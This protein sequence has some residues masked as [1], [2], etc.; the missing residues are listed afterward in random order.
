MKKII[1]NISLLFMF[2]IPFINLNAVSKDKVNYDVDAIYINSEIEIGGAVKF[3]EIIKVSG[4][5]NGYIRDIVYKNEKLNKFKGKKEDFYG[6]DIYNGSEIVVGRVGILNTDKLT[7]ENFENEFIEENVDFFEK[8]SDSTYEISDINNGTSIKMYKET[9]N[10]ET[11]FYLEYTILDLAVLHNDTAELYYNFIGDDFADDIGEVFAVVYLP[12]QDEEIKVWAHGPLNGEAFILEG[13]YGAALKINNLSKYTPIDLRILYNKEQYSILLNENKKS[14]MDAISLIKDVEEERAKTAN[15][16]RKRS[17]IIYYSL[18]SSDILYIIGILGLI[19][20]TYLKYDKEYKSSFFNKYNREFIEDYDVEIISYLMNKNINS[21]AF[22]SSILNLI[23]KKN[24]KVEKIN[25]KKEDYKFILLNKDNL[26]N[27]ENKIINLLF[28]EIGSNNE[29]LMSEIKKSSKNVYDSNKNKIYDTFIDWK[30]SVYNESLKQEFFEKNI[31]VKLLLSLYT[32]L[33]IFLG[34]LSINA[35]FKL[36]S[37]LV[38]ILSIV[39]LFYIIFFSKR[40]VKGN[41]HYI[42]WKAFK[43]FLNDFGRF[44]EKELPEIALWERYLV[45]ATVLG[46]ADKVSSDMKVKFEEMNV[47][48]KTFDSPLFTYY[49]MNDINRS[50]N[51][52]INKSIN[53]SISTVSAANSKMSSGSG[54]GGGF[55]SGGGFGGGGGGGRGF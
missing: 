37:V 21:N 8:Q 5:F 16:Q 27:N 38:I 1:L 28:S 12:F 52:E 17:K 15:N 11:Y 18:L 51:R 34:I 53:N 42:K 50:L 2:L 43:N 20:F 48:D 30:E 31:K 33:G 41:E 46:V 45:Y 4:T 25:S 23:Y 24:I 26:S 32:F 7:Y 19:I 14:N 22:S 10:S 39:Y 44:D 55:S 6:S 36:I 54:S 3:K 35:G 40:T 47:N 29:V 49:M 13:G 9:I